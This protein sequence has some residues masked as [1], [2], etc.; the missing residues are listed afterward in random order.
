MLVFDA[1]SPKNATEIMELAT[2]LASEN[3]STE[4]DPPSAPV[5]SEKSKESEIHQT[6]TALETTEQGNQAK[7]S[8]KL[9]TISSIIFICRINKKK[10]SNLKH[11]KHASKNS[12]TNL[13]LHL[14]S[15]DMR[16]PRRASL[17]K[18]LEKRKER[19]G[20]VKIF[21]FYICLFYFI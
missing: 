6:N 12:Y 14:L 4:E 5:T 1:F 10:T 21:H 19:Y 11:Y 3:P 16:Y 13:M 18:F 20:P 7:C 9:I 17:L 8:G 2:K 15:T